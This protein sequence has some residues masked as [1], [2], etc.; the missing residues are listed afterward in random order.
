M[1][2]SEKK[3]FV[4]VLR[5]FELRH[6]SE[7]QSARPTATSLANNSLPQAS[8]W[9]LEQY[10]KQGRCKTWSAG[11]S[12]FRARFGPSRSIRAFTQQIQIT[13]HGRNR[14]IFPHNK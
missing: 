4:S 12:V 1:L 5:S 13:I 8:A 11:E 9:Q 2:I 6:P 10:Q 14:R 3:P 7:S